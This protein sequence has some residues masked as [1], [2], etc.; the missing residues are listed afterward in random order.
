M[1]SLFDKNCF[2]E[3]VLT[4]MAEIGNKKW[5][6]KKTPEY[7]QHIHANWLLLLKKQFYQHEKLK[8]PWFVYN[9]LLP[10]KMICLFYPDLINACAA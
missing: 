7:R 8:T 9:F 2:Y 3:L 1:I 10:R 4:Q 5:R 6:Q